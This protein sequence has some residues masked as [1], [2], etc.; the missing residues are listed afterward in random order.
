MSEELKELAAPEAVENE[1]SDDQ[2]TEQ[3][4]VAAEASEVE[5]E[6][7]EKPETGE[8]DEDEDG[9][10]G[11]DDRPR[12]KSRSERL[13]RQN[14]RLQAEI[15]QL[16]SGSVQ[17]AV[18]DEDGIARAVEARIG[19]PPKEEDFKGDFL[20]F[21]R[22]QTAYELDKRQTT[23]EVKDRSARAVEVEQARIAERIE[24]YQDACAE[25]AKT[26]PDFF[27]VVKRPSFQTTELVKRLI[28]DAGEKAPLV[29]Y[30]LAQN[31]KL[32]ASLNAMSPIDA[33]REMGR[34]EGRVSAPKP[35]TA[36]SAAAP[37]S[38]VKG[39]AAPSNDETRMNA[40]LKKTYGR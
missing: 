22:A 4:K 18:Q 37:L 25:T 7:G 1:R 12:K 3:T 20:A 23:R 13:R 10:K 6:E 34:I 24:D 31:P 35:K 5:T 19:A 28:L 36:T 14:E 40:W 38:A 11:E 9:D 17:S 39:S 8:A 21:E 32:T 2:Q 30:H 15:A 27:D 33:A 16:R 26:L 29:A